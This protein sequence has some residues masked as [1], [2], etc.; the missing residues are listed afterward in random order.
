MEA[1]LSHLSFVLPCSNGSFCLAVFLPLFNFHMHLRLEVSGLVMKYNVGYWTWLL[2][3]DG[4]TA[5]VVLSVVLPCLIGSLQ[6]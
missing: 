3:H 2:D 4:H 6:S 5:S 1:C